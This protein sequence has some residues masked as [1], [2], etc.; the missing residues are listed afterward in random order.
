ML[1][2]LKI[3]YSLLCKQALIGSLHLSE[4]LSTISWVITPFFHLTQL[5][6]TLPA[7][8]AHPVSYSFLFPADRKWLE[9]MNTHTTGSRQEVISQQHLQPGNRTAPA[10]RWRNRP[11]TLT[12]MQV[13][14]IY[15]D[16]CRSHKHPLTSP[17]AVGIGTTTQE[18][19]C[20]H[21]SQTHKHSSSS[22][23]SVKHS[24]TRTKISQEAVV[25]LYV[26]FV[27]AWLSQG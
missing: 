5:F 7:L 23:E 2:Y 17:T 20:E 12:H 13:V 9:P 16:K 1:N 8:D 3:T 24:H 22:P 14:Y 4:V 6:V 26:C 25:H 11:R 18:T 10:G 21:I 27:F 15:T 19:E